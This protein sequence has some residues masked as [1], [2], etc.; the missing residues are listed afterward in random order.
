MIFIKFEYVTRREFS[1]YVVDGLAE[2]II[3]G[4]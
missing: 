4:Q 2:G 3:K 1:H